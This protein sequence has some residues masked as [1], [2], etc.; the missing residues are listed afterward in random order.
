M[1][2]HKPSALSKQG[3]LGVEFDSELYRYDAKDV[4]LS[5]FRRPLTSQIRL[6]NAV[7]KNYAKRLTFGFSSAMVTLLAL[8]YAATQRIRVRARTRPPYKFRTQRARSRCS[9]RPSL[10]SVN[11]C[12]QS[13]GLKRS[14]CMGGRDWMRVK[15]VASATCTRTAVFYFLLQ[16]KGNSMPE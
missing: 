6:N 7:L 2:V 10:S 9:A 15:E 3:W 8:L 13:H 14:H 5:I 12:P 11:G 4:G 1:R 16:F